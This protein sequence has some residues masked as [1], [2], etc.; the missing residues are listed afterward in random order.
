MNTHSVKLDPSRAIWRSLAAILLISGLAGLPQK[1]AQAL[2]IVLYVKPDGSTTGACNSWGHACMLQTA[3]ANSPIPGTTGNEIWVMEGDYYPDPAKT[4]RSA[5]FTLKNGVAIYGGFAGTEL[6]RDDRDWQVNT[7][8]LSGSINTILNTDNSYHVVTADNTN[9]TARL[10]GFTIRNGYANG[11]SMQQMGG[12][13]ISMS[14]SPT[15]ENI[16]FFG[17][18]A[19]L[20]GGGMWT[21]FSFAIL[22]NVTFSDNSANSGGGM[23][24]YMGGP[25]LLA[26]KFDGNDANV[27]GGG[28][29]NDNSDPILLEVTFE[30]NTAPYGGGMHNLFGGTATLTNSTFVNNI[31]TSGEGGGMSNYQSSPVL[32]NVTFQGNSTSTRGGA[33]ANYESI[34]VLNNVTLSGNTAVIEGGA[35][36]NDSSSNIIIK[37]SIIWG[38]SAPV[39]AQIHSISSTPVVTYSD[40]QG[41]YTGEGNLNSNPLLGD[42]GT[43]GSNI[44]VLPLLPGSPAIDAGQDSSCTPEDGRGFPGRCSITATWARMN[45]TVL[46]WLL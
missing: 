5:T 43:Y 25:N 10:D 33:M 1:T 2:T 37:N 3:L 23:H 12:G 44:Q 8:T 7:T 6:T 21:N 46:I 32:N 19:S 20:S 45:P 34:P 11:T 13:L 16:T 29:V 40:V 14:G 18:H 9:T 36:V 30:D 4:N 27:K 26:V 39:S 35:I 42:P 17:N 28:M 31:A 24:N 15:L 41:G 22:R 38:N